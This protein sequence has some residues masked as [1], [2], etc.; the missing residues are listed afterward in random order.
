MVGYVEIP[1]VG[2]IIVARGPVSDV[3]EKKVAL[4]NVY[5]LQVRL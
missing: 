5:I 3:M 2:L 1:L 4:P